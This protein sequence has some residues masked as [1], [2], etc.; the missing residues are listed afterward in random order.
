MDLEGGSVRTLELIPVPPV[1]RGRHERDCAR[2]GFARIAGVDEA[3]R[4]PLAGPVVAAA[5]ILDRSRRVRGI[6]DSKK[7][8]EDIRE[9]LYERITR[10]ARAWAVGVVEP[11]AID[12]LNILR[13]S[14]EA[15]RMAVAALPEPPDCLLIDGR[16]RI[17]VAI[18]QRPV[19]S[20]DALSIAIGAASIVAKV[21]RDRIMGELH[22]RWPDYNFGRHK[23]YATP[24]H[25]EALR[26]HGP[27][28]IHRRS[29]NGVLSDEDRAILLSLRRENEPD[30]GPF[31][32]T[33]DPESILTP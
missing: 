17:E 15:M 12:R 29:F 16:D 19:V 22:A 2:R 30:A 10:R 33:L 9:L 13:A 6:D 31:L 27:C 32:P 26:R 4:G 3:G 21:T 11:D 20:G 18:Y 8:P 5:V 1:R 14:L 7:L 24:E 28:P 25:L 23:G